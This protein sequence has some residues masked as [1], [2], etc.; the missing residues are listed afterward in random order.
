M[1]C[2]S[3]S[4]ITLKRI[5]AHALGEI[6]KHSAELASLVVKAG[7]LTYLSNLISH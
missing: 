6:S 5:A 2:L 3:E 7:A 1:L 4:E